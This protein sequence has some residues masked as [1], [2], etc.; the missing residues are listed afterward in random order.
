MAAGNSGQ[1]Q[2]RET[3]LWL[4]NAQWMNWHLCADARCQAFWLINLWNSFAGSL[5]YT[6]APP[7]SASRSFSLESGAL[8]FSRRLDE[9]EVSRHTFDGIR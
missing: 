8:A 4:K 5:K 1:G 2:V 3:G 7:S 9:N 6:L